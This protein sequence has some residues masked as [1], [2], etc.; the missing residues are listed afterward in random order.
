MYFSTFTDA[1]SKRDT[2]IWLFGNGWP[3]SGSRT[4]TLPK[5]PARCSAVGT[6]ATFVVPTFWR[7]V[8]CHPAKKNVLPR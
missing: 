4:V 2:G 5:L 8:P 6:V 1:G 3:V 7:S